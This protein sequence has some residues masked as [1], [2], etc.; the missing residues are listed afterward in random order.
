MEYL[1]IVMLLQELGKE[2]SVTNVQKILTDLDIEEDDARIQL[3]VS[4]LSVLRSSKGKEISKVSEKIPDKED[5]EFQK[6]F[7]GLE[8]SL[9]T[10]YGLLADQKSEHSPACQCCHP[11][12]VHSEEVYPEEVHQEEVHQEEVHQEEVYQEEVH[13]EEVDSEV[14]QAA[15]VSIMDRPPEIMEQCQDS[16]DQPGRYIYGI[17]GKGIREKLGAIGLDGAEVY[18]IPYKD[19]CIVV[20]DCMA[21]P[22]KSENEDAVKEWLFTQQEVLDKAV[23]RFEGVLPMGFDMI[24][25]GKNGN[26]PETEA[27]SWLEKNYDS[28]METMA[29]IRNRQEYGIQVI[30]DTGDLSERL[31]QTDEKLKKKKAEID[32]KPEGIAYMEREILKDLV[33]ER[34]EEKADEYFK[35]FY[36][37]IKKCTDD[38][39]IGKV[40]KV[41]GS[42]QMLMNLSCLVSNEMVVP[43]GEELEKIENNDGIT[44]RFSGPW[45]PYSFVTPE[46]GVTGNNDG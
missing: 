43:L 8:N 33:K 13:S 23:E 27:I 3:L 21:E 34:I 4:A 22:Y 31:L 6:R 44:V 18:T 20:H 36:H 32:A 15:E 41:G 29:K 12:E 24:I 38:I 7:E 2:I 39:V 5:R 16:H 35:D 40:K 11:K 1:Y 30:L 17:G 14:V 28:F 42:Q 25:E 37:L 26:D 19:L 45:A 46:K 10:L 9:S